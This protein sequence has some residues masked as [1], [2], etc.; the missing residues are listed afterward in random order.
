MFR[1]HSNRQ[2]DVG[3]VRLLDI[4]QCPGSF[5]SP[6]KVIERD[7]L[8]TFPTDRMKNGAKFKLSIVTADQRI[9]ADLQS[10]VFSRQHISKKNIQLVWVLNKY[11]TI[12]ETHETAP[13]L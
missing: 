4:Y 5:V 3:P 1:E 12:S 11:S 7:W 9:V 8:K 2:V 13:K 10:W 6:I